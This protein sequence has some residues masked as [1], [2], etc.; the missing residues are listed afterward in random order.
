M[1]NYYNRFDP[2]KRWVELMAIPGRRLQAAEINEIQA[3]SL[4]RDKCLGDALFG[5]GHILDGCQLVLAE[6]RTS[7]TISPG[8]IYYD[9]MVH[10]VPETTL[11]LSGQGEETIGIK[12]EYQ[13]VTYEQDPE[14]LDPALGFENFGLPGM[15][16]RVASIRWVVNDP[17]AIPVY[18]LVNG[19]LVRQ[20]TPPELEGI[21]PILARRTYDTSGNFLV[22]GMD[23][24]IEPKD[25]DYVTL[26]IEAGKAYVGGFE[27]NKLVPVKIAVPKAKETRRVINE[28]KV[29]QL[30]TD[31]YPLNSKPVKEIITLTATVEVTENITRGNIPGTTDALPKTPVVDVVEVKQGSTVYQRGVDW[32]LSGNAIDWSLGGAEPAGGTTYTVTYRYVKVMVAGTDYSLDS[33]A[34][35]FLS[36]D[37]PVD[38][39]TFQVTYDFFLARK[40]LFYL[41]A[42]GE[43]V[44]IQGQPEVAPPLPVAPPDV[45]VLGELYLPPNSDQ[46]QVTNYKPKRLTMLEL[47]SLL[48]RLE[49]AEY[50]QAIANL[51]KEAQLADPTT[52]KKGIFTDNFSNFERADIAHPDFDATFDPVAKVLMLPVEQV[53]NDLVVDPGVTTARLHERLATLPYSEEV[54]IEQ[55]AA[56]E[57]WNVNPYQVF[58]NQAVIRL[59]ASHDSW[60]EQSVVTRV[61]WNWWDPWWN[62]TRTEARIILE[63]DVPFI[64][65]KEV[66]VYGENFLPNSD[67]IQ[68]TFDGIPV[69]LTPVG[70]TQPGT[71]PGTVKADAQGKFVAKF[72]IPPNVRT[73]T[74]EVRAFNLV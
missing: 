58:D 17:G 12:I 43:I 2:S 64:R 6:D 19:E 51:E 9:G 27:I 29:Y 1:A 71:Q 13:V 57:A 42:Q 47:R 62:G 54:I 45:L 49:R 68:V 20:T 28:T 48:D 50:N 4:Y 53:V 60:V 21:A 73:G 10:D 52:V 65:Q 34:V 61:V 56:T 36:G 16:R 24:Y 5:A 37:R 41:T 7:A 46:V 70:D 18:R 22:S 44:V 32:Q 8:R 38:G 63:E 55:A 14:L 11:A 31:T 67:N 74:K 3:L 33:D 35:K 15:D 40:D 69:T 30:G 25:A 72:T 66:F 39:T 59:V 23:A 26:V